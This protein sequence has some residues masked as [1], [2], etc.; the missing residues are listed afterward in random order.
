MRLNRGGRG[1]QL[2]EGGA[3]EVVEAAYGADGEADQE[4]P[5]GRIEGAVEPQTQ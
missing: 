5:R 3:E 2:A 1:L 4:S